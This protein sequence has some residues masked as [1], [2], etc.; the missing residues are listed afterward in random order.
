ML[1][2]DHTAGD[3]IIRA[4]A[5]ISR[6]V[7]NCCSLLFLSFGFL[8][9]GARAAV[10]EE[11]YIARQGEPIDISQI[12][13]GQ[14]RR[15]ELDGEPVFVRRLR[16]DELEQKS[17]VLENTR[18][19]VKGGS[20]EWIA[21]SGICTHAGCR[22]LQGLGPQGGF[23]CPCHGSEFDIYGRVLRGPAAHNLPTVDCV[24]SDNTLT[25]T[26]EH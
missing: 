10:Y 17:M 2:K 19:S 21:V 5:S 23:L 15:F 14:W 20:G 1:N 7:L 25:F 9:K 24:I 22:I 11:A 12:S 16:P 8:K 26:K 13:A 18:D 6:R 4:R 3:G